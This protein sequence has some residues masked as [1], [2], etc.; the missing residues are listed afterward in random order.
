MTPGELLVIL[1]MVGYAVYRQTQDH[2][3]EGSQ[4]FK[5]A[6]IYGI[7]GLV[8]GGFNVPT[9]VLSWIFLVLSVA[10]SVVVGLARG[11][12][13][14][15]WRA[16][17]GALHTQGTPLTIGLM[18]GMIVIKFALGTIAHFA[19]AADDGGI[20]EIILMIAIMIAFQ[21]EIVWRRGLRLAAP[22]P[23]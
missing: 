17:D 4:R 2:V 13:Q 9:A 15:V 10:L 3:V 16:T 1:A 19:D 14:R 21:A 11:R 22:V 8:V 23:A 12:L 18:L 6:V 20:G 7:V 5:L